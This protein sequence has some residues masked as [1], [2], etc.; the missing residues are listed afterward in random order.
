MIVNGGGDTLT[1]GCTCRRVPGRVLYGE[2]WSSASVMRVGLA[3]RFHYD[4]TF[5]GAGEPQPFGVREYADIFPEGFGGRDTFGAF[6]R[7]SSGRV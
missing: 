4:C 7:R 1:S 2:H 6:Q 5:R 3:G